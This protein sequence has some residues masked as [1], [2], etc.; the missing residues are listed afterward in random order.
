MTKICVNEKN[1]VGK[2]KAMH[3][4]G[5]P[6]LLGISTAKFSYLTEAN[7][8]YSRL[9]DVGGWFGK[10]MFVDIPNIFRDFDADENDPA[11]YD[12]T[13]TDILIKGLIDAGCEPHYRLGVSIENFSY[14]KA[15]RIFPPKDY[16]K[17]ARICEHVIRHYN[18][19]W[20]DGFHFG[21]KYWEI[22]NEPD[23]H[24]IIEENC[25]WRGTKEQYYDLYRVASKHLKKCFGDSIKVG[26]YGSCGFY[27]IQKTPHLN[28]VAFGNTQSLKNREKR[29]GYFMDFF[30]EF[31][32]IV[33]KEN[34]PF[35]FFS[36]HSYATVEDN[37]I[38]QQFCEK[39]L[40]E[41]GLG[42]VEIH[43]DEWNTAATVEELGKS[44]ACATAVANMCGLQNTKLK[45][46]CYYDAKIY[47]GA[48][49]GLFNCLTKE[50]YCAY[51]GFKAFGK[52]YALGNQ[53]EC[54]TD[55]ELVFANAATDGKTTAVLVS[56]I[57]EDTEIELSANG[58]Y[59]A[60]LI[61]ETH[62]FAEVEMKDNCIELKQNQ[63]L[64]LEKCEV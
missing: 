29:D 61:D 14:I 48:Y 44:V 38:K 36:H 1:V 21:I 50:P 4:V 53:I 17:W 13:F 35:D 55:N 41:K 43:L 7:I 18:E 15:Y 2:I 47:G 32:D 25:L 28:G 19:G 49:G 63:V 31:I 37:I 27:Q 45:V 33:C 34:L 58:E 12:F 52:L 26:G 51:Y 6:P 40:E 39:Y 57:G 24:Y 60:Y 62:T 16:D 56:N 22:W 20:A 64:Y 46:A 3:G 8:P 23:L 54:K 30:Y 42:D 11:S 5:Q 9:H 59:S 10:N